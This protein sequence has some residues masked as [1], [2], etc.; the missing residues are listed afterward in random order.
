M[1]QIVLHRLGRQE[2][3]EKDLLFLIFKSWEVLKSYADGIT[4][5]AG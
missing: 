1:N 4:E 2:I 3:K 5:V